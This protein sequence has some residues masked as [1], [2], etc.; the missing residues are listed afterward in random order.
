[1]LV[2]LRLSTGLQKA[3]PAGDAVYFQDHGQHTQEIAAGNQ[4]T[5]SNVSSQ[6]RD[7]L[8]AAKQSLGINIELL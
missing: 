4:W 7:L 3:W 6:P 1:M 8:S 2:E 5:E